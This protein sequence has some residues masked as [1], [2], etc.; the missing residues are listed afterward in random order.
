M[1]RNTIKRFTQ[2]ESAAGILLFA[3]AALSMQVA[4]SPLANLMTEVLNTRASVILGS[5]AIDKSDLLWI[6]DGLMAVFFLLVGLELKRE[7]MDRD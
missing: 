2:L 7:V 1:P 5:L 3:A 4:N 6:N